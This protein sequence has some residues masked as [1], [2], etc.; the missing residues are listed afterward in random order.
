MLLLLRY[1]GSA[2]RPEDGAARDGIQAGPNSD[3]SPVDDGFVDS[4]NDDYN[5]KEGAEI[6]NVA[7]VLNWD[8]V[9]AS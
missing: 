4:A 2:G 9:P 3:D 1:R 8:D 5:V 7:R 6:R